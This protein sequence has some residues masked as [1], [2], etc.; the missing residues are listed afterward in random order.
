[1]LNG[2][3]ERS[4]TIG[5]LAPAECSTVAL[6][7]RISPDVVDFQTLVSSIQASFWAASS[8]IFTGC[9]PYQPT[10][11]GLGPR[12]YLAFRDESEPAADPA[13][14]PLR[15]DPDACQQTS[16]FQ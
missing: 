2:E 14:I 3:L 12:I 11:H 10:M 16:M 6:Q 9:C 7:A 8:R 4:E 13:A 5:Q 15:S 1:M